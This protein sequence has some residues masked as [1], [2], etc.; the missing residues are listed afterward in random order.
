MRHIFPL[1]LVLSVL[2]PGC[3]T[4]NRMKFVGK[5]S[6]TTNLPKYT[7]LANY[8]NTTELMTD[9]TYADSTNRGGKITILETGTYQIKGDIITFYPMTGS[10]VGKHYTNHIRNGI[11]FTGDY[12]K[13]VK[14]N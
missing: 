14:E 11:L 3:A 6:R 7:G 4:N 10:E 1:F 8:T 13:R 12:L 2:I 9:G 5:Y